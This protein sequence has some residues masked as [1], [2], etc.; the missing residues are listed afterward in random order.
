MDSIQDGIRDGILDKSVRNLARWT[1][2]AGGLVLI[3]VIVMTCISISLR[4]LGKFGFGT[5]PVPGDFELVEVGIAFAIFAFLPWCQL[6]RGHA[7]VDVFRTVLGDRENRLIDLVSD[8]L[9][10]TIAVLVA[11]RLGLGMLD[12]K[13]YSETTFILEFPVW[14]S[15]AAG[16]AG[17]V[18][19]VIVATYCATRSAAA[20]LNPVDD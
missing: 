1:A 12:K 6:Q 7:S 16:L 14:I 20:F 10:L 4:A 5:G 11:W 17:A 8:F 15:Y 9:M 13:G 19:F 18:V 3:G 2:L